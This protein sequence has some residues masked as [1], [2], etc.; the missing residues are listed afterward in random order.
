MGNA[1]WLLLQSGL[2]VRLLRLLR[3]AALLIFGKNSPCGVG[4]TP[5]ERLGETGNAATTFAHYDVCIPQ[6]F[7]PA[8]RTPVS[9]L[10]CSGPS[11]QGARDLPS[12]GAGILEVVDPTRKGLPAARADR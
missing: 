9:L 10:Y 5:A 6:L 7:R 1:G 2:A 12:L 3:S 11:Q 8:K 4:V